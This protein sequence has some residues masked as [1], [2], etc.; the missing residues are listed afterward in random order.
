MTPDLRAIVANAAPEAL[1]ALIGLLAEAQ[2]AALARL[3]TPAPTN[4]N[5]HAES[6]K[7]ISTKEAARRLGVSEDWLYRQK[8]L[9]FRRQIGRR[10]LFSAR[11]L[12]RWNRSR[13]GRP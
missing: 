7:N 5:G 13:S 12:E 4:G 8:K 9:P 6:D 10:V 1:P 2:A 11:D 3:T